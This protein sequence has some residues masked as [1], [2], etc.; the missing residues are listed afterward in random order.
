MRN[1]RQL[2]AAVVLMLALSACAFA[3]IIG[4]SPEA[5][6]QAP[7]STMAPE[8]IGAPPTEPSPAGPSDTVVDVA[9]SLLQSALL[10]F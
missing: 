10:M 3:G 7:S 1:L 6:P 4:T 8:P 5:P 9:L 2:G